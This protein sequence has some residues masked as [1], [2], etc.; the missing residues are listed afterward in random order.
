MQ[1]TIVGTQLPG[2]DCGRGHNF[3]GHANIHV[4]VQRK[5]RP[6]ELLDLQR[7][8]ATVARW[9][10]DCSVDGLDV[11]G[12]FIQGPPGGRFIYLSWGSVDAE[13][14]FSMFRR[15]KLLLADVPADIM[16][17]AP[18]SGVLVG[19][20]RLTDANGQPLCASVRPPQIQWAAE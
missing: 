13:G 6:T 9:T 3:P 11:R 20:L 15:A 18:T 19:R 17:A 2:L 8:D 16:A 1:V 7:G 12:P 14:V 5:N 10:L 4:G